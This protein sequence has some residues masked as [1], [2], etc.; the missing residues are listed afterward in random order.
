MLFI[1][2]K[3]LLFRPFYHL[4]RHI[5]RNIS[6]V[7]LMFQKIREKENLQ[8]HEDNKQFDKNNSPQRFAYCHVPK[9]IIIQ[10]KCTIKECSY[11]HSRF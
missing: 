10:I 4:A 8:N 7:N 9:S 11:L 5:I 2:A 1:I 3:Y 6:M